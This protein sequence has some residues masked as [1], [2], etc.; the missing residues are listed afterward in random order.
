LSEKHELLLLR[1]KLAD[2]ERVRNEL[3]LRL[4][5]LEKEKRDM[6]ADWTV[7]GR[8]QT[9]ELMEATVAI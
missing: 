6:E 8:I 7:N 1:Q 2:S 5:V 4:K 9:A 3:E